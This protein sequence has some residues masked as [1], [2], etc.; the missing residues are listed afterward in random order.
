[1]KPLPVKINA[2]DNPNPD[3]IGQGENGGENNRR[4]PEH[5]KSVLSEALAI[6]A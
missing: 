4:Q 1:M 2:D 5:Q 3:A 6:K